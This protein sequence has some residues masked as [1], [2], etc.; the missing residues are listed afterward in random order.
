MGQVFSPGVLV[1]LETTLNM[2]VA[3]TAPINSA[4]KFEA[5]L[6]VDLSQ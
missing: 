1:Y 3:I 5:V 2:E 6:S 4:R